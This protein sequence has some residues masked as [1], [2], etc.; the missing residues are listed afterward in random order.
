MTDTPTPT[1][2]LEN[3][4][5]G[6]TV[7][8]TIDANPESFDMHIWGTSKD[9]WCGTVACLAG[10]IMLAS[11]YRLNGTKFHR[12]DGDWVI[13]EGKEAAHLIGL[14]GYSRDL[15]TDYGYG[16]DRFRKLVE[17]AEG[18]QS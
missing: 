13:N 18:R 6:R 8:D 1:L 12:P 3:A 14:T 7:L 16:L 11:G 15:W 4:E 2:R 10:H 5:L 17:E 9:P